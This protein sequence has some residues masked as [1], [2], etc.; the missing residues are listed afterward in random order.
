MSGVLDGGE[1]N[2]I[3]CDMQSTCKRAT[4][5]SALSTT[6]GERTIR[7]NES[8]LARLISLF[9]E[10]LVTELKPRYRFGPNIMSP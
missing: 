3:Q 7:A 10:L 4:V 1:L 8:W 9:A 2:H 6:T 5:T